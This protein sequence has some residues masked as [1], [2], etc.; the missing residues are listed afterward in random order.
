MLKGEKKDKNEI[1]GVSLALSLL[2]V[3][4]LAQEEDSE[5][6]TYATSVH[7]DAAQ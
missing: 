7:C 3:P 6:Y 2:A 1:N 5:R 4:A